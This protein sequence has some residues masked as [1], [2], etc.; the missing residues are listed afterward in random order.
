MATNNVLFLPTQVVSDNEVLFSN[1]SKD[2]APLFIAYITRHSHSSGLPCGNP[3]GNETLRIAQIVGFPIRQMVQ[4]VHF[5]FSLK[6]SIM[7][8]NRAIICVVVWRQ[9]Q[10][11]SPPYVNWMVEHC[12]VVFTFRVFHT[13]HKYVFILMLQAMYLFR[14][15]FSIKY[16]RYQHTG[17]IDKW[18]EA[19]K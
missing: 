12:V 7:G 15:S 5:L 1:C 9:Q 10:A 11:D 13:M 14:G 2:K 4:I 19:E 8:D 17:T 3:N 6:T 18:S 16:C